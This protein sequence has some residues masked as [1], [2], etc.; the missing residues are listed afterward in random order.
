VLARLLFDDA[1]R[2]SIVHPA[3]ADVQQEWRD[4]GPDW[5]RRCAVRSQGLWTFCKLVALVSVDGM[6]AGVGRARSPASDEFDPTTLAILA[7]LFF[8]S[9]WG[10]PLFGWFT[11]LA[12]GGGFALAAVLR[13]RHAHRQPSTAACPL[14]LS[15]LRLETERSS[16]HARSDA[17]V[18]ISL[19]VSVAVLAQWMR[20]FVWFLLGALASGV[21]CAGALW[22]WRTRVPRR[23]A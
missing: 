11:A 5:R 4:A 14:S 20:G 8:A 18:L 22:I 10:W 12:L 1:T 21:L 9:A 13:W 19:V 3:I 2:S 7:I 23:T 16:T 15:Q 6:R 17:A